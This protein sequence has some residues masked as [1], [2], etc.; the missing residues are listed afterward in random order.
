[1]R[2]LN[3]LPFAPHLPTLL[4]FARGCKQMSKFEW[5]AKRNACRIG[6][7]ST[8][9]G[10]IIRAEVYCK[11]K[12]HD[13]NAQSVQVTF[14]LCLLCCRRLFG[15]VCLWFKSYFR[16]IGVEWSG[17][18]M[19]GR[20]GCALTAMAFTDDIYFV[21]LCGLKLG[22][23]WLRQYMQWTYHVLQFWNATP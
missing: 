15:A 10:S 17:A 4:V 20:A 12:H 19:E 9:K 6:W 13:S 11:R 1:M 23:L 16:G 8:K 22:R 7:D 18:R 3:S 5:I 21:F 2:N 14:F